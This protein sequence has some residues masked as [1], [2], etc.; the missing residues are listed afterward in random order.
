VPVGWGIF[1]ILPVLAGL[2]M[3]TFAAGNL[4][5]HF[6]VYIQ[7]L[8]NIVNIVLRLVF[9]FTGIFYDIEK[10]IPVP[11]K[12]WVLRINPLAAYITEAR[13]ALLYGRITHWGLLIAWVVLSLILDV[14]TVR[15][16]YKNEN[17]YV[18]VI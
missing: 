10:R 17:G 16:V 7:D 14:V 11:Y 1:Y 3:T 13:Y 15:V 5:M 6:G 4:I 8:S 12:Y 2:F 18:K 9:Y